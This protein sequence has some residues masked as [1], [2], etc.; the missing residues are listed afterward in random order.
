MVLLGRSGS[1][2]SRFVGSGFIKIVNGVASLV[3]S[4]PIKITTLWHRMY[5]VLAGSLPVPGEPL[6]FPYFT[7]ADDQ[8]NLHGIRGENSVDSVPVWSGTDL[9]FSFVPTGDLPACRKGSLDREL[10]V[11]LVGFT[12]LSINDATDASRCQVGMAGEGVALLVSQDTVNGPV[13]AA[14]VIDNPPSDGTYFLKCV[15]GVIGWVEEEI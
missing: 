5:K 15:D 3:T 9:T 11:E 10:V 1:T 7:I 6:P 8:G 14:R 13:S 12:P 2:L 4:V